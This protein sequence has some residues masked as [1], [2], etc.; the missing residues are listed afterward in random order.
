MSFIRS[1]PIARLGA[2]GFALM[3]GS[4]CSAEPAP[5]PGSESLTAAERRAIADTVESLMRAATDLSIHADTARH[6]ADAM[7]SLYPD[8]GEVVSASGGYMIVGRD[9]LASA[10]HAFW[11]NVGISMVRPEWRWGDFHVDVLARDAAVLTASYRIPH[12]TPTG[13]AHVVGGVWTA[14]FANRNGEW[15]IVQ[16]HLSD[17]PPGMSLTPE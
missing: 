11:E 17:A 15:I 5:P 4:A 16:E 12:L 3:L 9:S 1:N 13:H 2:L 6:P 14:V 10:V 8:S 7:L